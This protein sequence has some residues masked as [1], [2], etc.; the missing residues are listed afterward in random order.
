MISAVRG[1]NTQKAGAETLVKRVRENLNRIKPFQI[2]FIQQVYTD[3]ELSIEESGEILF[4]DDRHLKWTYLK[5]DFKVF[6]LQEDDYKFYDQ[7]NGQVTV[8]KIRDRGRQWLW[9]LFFSEDILRY[10]YTDQSSPRKIFIKKENVEEPLDIEIMLNNDYLPIQV[11]Q[12][13]FNTG[14]RMIFY[15][16]DYKEKISITGDTLTLKV[17]KDV[18]IVEETGNK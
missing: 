4:K 3:E 9:Q 1:E 8:G 6:L 16:S 12:H 10:S 11:I 14:A 7:E 18:E 17:P 15:F 2:Q 5:P 13:D